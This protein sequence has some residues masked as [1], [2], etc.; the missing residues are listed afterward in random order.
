MSNN[1]KRVKKNQ[2]NTLTDKIRENPWIL[3]TIVLG[4][5]LFVLIVGSSSSLSKIG[6]SSK[7]SEI[8]SSKDVGNEIIGLVK[9]QFPNAKLSDVVLKN[10]IYKVVVLI[11]NEEIPIYVT[12]DGKN[13]INGGITPLSIVKQ[14]LESQNQ[15]QAQQKIQSNVSGI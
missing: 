13:L 1:K 3:S 11:N 12:Q 5:L 7:N 10:G 15:L 9:I 4:V 6:N 14:Q 2:R 8:A